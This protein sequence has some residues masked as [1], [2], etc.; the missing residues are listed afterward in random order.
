MFVDQVKIFVK[1][2]DG[3]N[4]CVSFRRE[5]HVPRGG[6]DGGVGGK[7]GDVVLV[8]VSHQNT[9]LPLRYHTE[10]RADRG[11]H[12]GP[13]NRTGRRRRGPAR[14]GAAGHL[15]PRRGDRR[16]P[17]RGAPGRRP[18]RGRA[19]R[20]RRPRQPL[21]PLEPQPRAARGRSRASR[22][23]S[24]GCASTSGSSPT[25]ACWGC[26]TPESRR[27]CPASP[28]RARRSP[29]TR[30]RPSRRCSG[31]SRSTARSFVVADIPGIIEGAAEGAG[32]G[33]QFL[34]ARRAHARP[35]P[36]R[37]R[38]GDERA[39]PRRRPAPAS[40]TRSGS[41]DATLLERPQLVVGHE[42]R[43][44]R[45]R[46]TRCPAC[47]RQAA[48][49]GLE[50]MPVSAVTGEGLLAL[51]RRLL[52]LVDASRATDATAEETRV[53]IGL[54][55]G[56]FDPVHLGHLRAAENAREALAP[57][58]R[59]SSCRAPCRRTADPG[60]AGRRPARDGPPR[61]GHAP[62]V[63]GLGRR[64]APRRPELHGRHRAAPCSRSGRATRSSSSSAADTWPE[65][66][67]WREPERLFSL[68][69]GRRRGAA[70]V[71]PRAADGRRSRRRARSTA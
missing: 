8:A 7:G 63:R 12:G 49:L 18:A 48:S 60:D 65:M 46:T 3:G 10:Y 33:L 61:R 57:R 67:T 55:G 39:R 4:G 43:R 5:A 14:P 23:R 42:A 13:G 71:A 68:V 17:R 30:S 36:R 54:F 62:R 45:P 22:A 41:W 37:R 40:A 28:R 29:T 31:W 24:A 19:R 58:P 56:T 51:K 32:L 34:Q 26:R 44:R 69:R 2:G 50:V 21:V 6:P 15:G 59:R 27:S 53:R 11:T 70:G 47:A 25:W 20:P 16:G 38:L 35:R 64:A 1:G 9:L 66:A 52:A